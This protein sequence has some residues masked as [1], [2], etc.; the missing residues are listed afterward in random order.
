MNPSRRAFLRGKISDLPPNVPTDA[1][2]PKLA[3]IGT[4]CLAQRRVECR[5]CG[6]NCPHSAIRFKP[7]LGG[8]SQPTVLAEVCTGCG[9]CVAPC[10]AA[11]IAIKTLATHAQ[12]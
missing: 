9:E 3:H 11:A 1:Q 12:P 8:V 7:V 4:Q 2:S 10:P 5:V 6:E